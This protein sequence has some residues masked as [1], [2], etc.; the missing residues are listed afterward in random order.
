[1]CHVV[2]IAAQNV[3]KRVKIAKYGIENTPSMLHNAV[4]LLLNQDKSTRVRR[5]ES[6]IVL[7][8]LST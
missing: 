5:N 7:S 1:M 3:N 2:V 4:F 6:Q 8:Q